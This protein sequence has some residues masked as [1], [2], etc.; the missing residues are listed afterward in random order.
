MHVDRINRSAG[1][2]LAAHTAP[3]TPADSL[4]MQSTCIDQ[5]SPRADDVPARQPSA[6]GVGVS[7]DCDAMRSTTDMFVVKVASPTVPEVS[8]QR[9]PPAASMRYP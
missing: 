9:G 5:G 1:L 4:D 6:H 2:R 8:I 3:E 7:V